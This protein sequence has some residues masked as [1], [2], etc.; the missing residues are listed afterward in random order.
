ME[1][2]IKDL[3]IECLKAFASSANNLYYL[4]SSE[5][6]S[7]IGDYES[8]LRDSSFTIETL[9]DDGFVL[10]K[11]SIYLKNV[12]FKD[13]DNCKRFEAAYLIQSCTQW[14]TECID[15]LK[16]GIA[17]VFK[18]ATNL[19]SLVLIRDSVIQFES[20]LTNESSQNTNW[21]LVCQTLFSKKIE[22]WFELISPFYYSQFKVS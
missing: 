20:T 11:I 12:K 2:N 17:D 14:L 9:K 7:E 16:L 15:E 18:Y 3:I 1:A 19:R 13:A 8:L 4:F 22:L 10:S 6:A 21:N 5:C